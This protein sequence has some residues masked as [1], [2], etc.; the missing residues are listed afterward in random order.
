MQSVQSTEKRVRTI[1]FGFQV[2]SKDFWLVEKV[3]RHFLANHKPQQVKT[4]A[5][6][7]VDT[8]LKTAPMKSNF[9]PC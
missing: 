6:M 9:T 2:T 5:I 7:H 3:A 1:G 4:T 8:Q